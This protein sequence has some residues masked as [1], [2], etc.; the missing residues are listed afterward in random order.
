MIHIPAAIIYL[1]AIALVILLGSGITAVAKLTA[2]VKALEQLESNRASI[3][4]TLKARALKQL[5]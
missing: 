2:R 4:E 3:R 5:E 1:T